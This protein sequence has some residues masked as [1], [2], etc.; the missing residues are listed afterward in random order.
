ART[1]GAGLVVTF[2]GDATRMV[3]QLD[4]DLFDLGTVGRAGYR[5]EGTGAKQGDPPGRTPSHIYLDGVLKDQPLADQGALALK[6]IYQVPVEPGIEA[7]GQAGS[8][9]GCEHRVG[10]QHGV[11]T[12]LIDDPLEDVDSWLGQRGL[13]PVSRCQIDLGRAELPDIGY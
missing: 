7:G 2:Q 6:Q 1:L 11:V 8:H 10:E 12:V 13:Q 9:I 4:R 5:L 3:V